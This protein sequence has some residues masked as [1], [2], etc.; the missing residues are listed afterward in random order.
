LHLDLCNAALRS[1]KELGREEI[2]NIVAM[3]PLA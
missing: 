1:N 2:A 3:R